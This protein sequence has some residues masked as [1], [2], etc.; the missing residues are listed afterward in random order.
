MVKGVDLRL[1]MHCKQL[2]EVSN[3]TGG[4]LVA[5]LFSNAEVAELHHDRSL[6][7]VVRAMVL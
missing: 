4:R 1:E 5:C 2:R 6:S 3:P 7:S